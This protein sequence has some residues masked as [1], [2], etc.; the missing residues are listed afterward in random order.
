MIIRELLD[1]TRSYLAEKDEKPVDDF[2]GALNWAMDPRRLDP[3]PLPCL[4]HLDGNL[5]HAGEKER[6]LIRFIADHGRSL[7]WGQT[8]TAE[9]FGEIFL[10]NYGWVELFG[11]RGHFANDR[12]AGGFLLLGPHI[13]YPDHHHIAEE[14]YIPLTSGAEWR[15]GDT[16]FRKRQAGEVIHHAPNV[17]HAMR[18]GDAPLLAFYL[19]RGG[20]LDQ[21]ST[22]GGRMEKA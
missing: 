8:Y 12:M 21:R 13:H 18:T 10:Q 14:I 7:A 17:V 22:I 6:L 3:R 15:A 2:I 5:G 4:T 19:W 20:P 11:T 9:D 1:R 16:G